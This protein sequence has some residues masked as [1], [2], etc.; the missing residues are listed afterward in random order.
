MR[1][2]PHY[3]NLLTSEF[4]QKYYVDEKMSYPQIREML[5]GHGFNIHVGTLH[6]YAKKLGFGRSVSEAMRNDEDAGYHLDWTKSFLTETV[7]ESIDGFLLGDG[8]MEGSPNGQA[9][10]AT[11]G[12][13]YQDFCYYMMSFFSDYGSST[14]KYQDKSMTQGFRWQGRTLHHPDLWKQYV[15]WYP[16]TNGKRE[17]QPPDD[18]RITPKSVMIWYL[19]DGTLIADD[20]TNTV[21]IRLSTDSFLPER[22]E[23]LVQKLNEK[24]IACHRS[25]N[26]RVLIEA[27]GIPGLFAFIGKTSPVKSYDYKFEMPEWR[28]SAK[29][30]SDVA[31]ELGLDYQRLAYLV[32]IGK[33]PALRASDKGRPRFLAEHIEICKQMKERGEL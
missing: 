18:V 25:N 8:G 1:E 26:N 15:R 11:C 30:M 2:Q 23:M 28:F 4:F 24:G 29:R 3:A 19:G 22:V 7:I 12:V 33:I 31:K 20:D 32:K 27:K 13:E 17:K 5:L 6:A 14:S 16:E 21:I 9:G 10:R